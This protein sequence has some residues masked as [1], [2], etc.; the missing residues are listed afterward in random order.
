[1]LWDTQKI[2][3]TVINTVMRLVERNSSR[4]AKELREGCGEES[5]FTIYMYENA[6]DKVCQ[7]KRFKRLT[8]I[9]LVVKINNSLSFC[10]QPW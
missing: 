2:I 8:W 5:D 10:K 7:Q 6:K 9:L 1:M 3:N 4:H